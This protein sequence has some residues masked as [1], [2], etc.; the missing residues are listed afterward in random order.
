MRYHWF[1]ILYNYVR[2]FREINGKNRFVPNI[3]SYIIIFFNITYV[4]C[5]FLLSLL[6]FKVMP[7]WHRRLMR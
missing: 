3:L 7:V 2:L 6:Q 1:E 4:Y 5:I